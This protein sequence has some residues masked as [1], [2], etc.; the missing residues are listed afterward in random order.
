MTPYERLA[1]LGLELPPVP[2]PVANFTNW[3][4]EGD[5]IFISGQGPV[6]PDGT[7][8]TG[9]LGAGVGIEAAYTHARLTGLNLIAVMHEALSDLS[10]VKR[11]VKLLGMV[12]AAPDFAEH[13]K[14]IN[15]CSDLMVAVFGEKGVHT[16]SAVGFSS[17]P[18]GIT[19][20][21][22]AVIAVED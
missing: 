4:R 9:R 18:F 5:L 10:R 14:V 16:R 21:I 3:V 12:N 1:G 6:E 22:E 8:H 15:G 17:L 19:V 20:E 2:S 11:V 7:R 13:P